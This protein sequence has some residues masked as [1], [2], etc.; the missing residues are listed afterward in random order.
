MLYPKIQSLTTSVPLDL[1]RST[2]GTY[3]VTQSCRLIALGGLTGLQSSL[4]DW[5]LTHSLPS[6]LSV[7]RNAALQSLVSQSSLGRAG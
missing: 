1:G 3:C 7:A 6:G 4:P 5:I 2:L